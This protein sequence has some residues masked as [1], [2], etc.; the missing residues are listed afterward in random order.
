MDTEEVRMR[1]ALLLIAIVGA[2]V[3]SPVSSQSRSA[4]EQAFDRLKA[5]EGTWTDVDGTFGAKGAAAVTYKVTSG[6]HSVVE[7][8]PVGTPYEMVTVY[9]LDGNDLV[10]THY[11]SSNNQPRMKS[12]GLQG[13]LIQFAFAGGTNIDPA[14]TSHMHSARIELISADEI[15][16]TW[17]NWDQGKS[18]HS[19]T[20]RVVRKK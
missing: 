11:C 2:G 15:R 6:G 1:Y 3:I 8:F 16:A 18:D 7:T 9:H 20:F 10:L 12:A 5:L 13:N 19:A 14:K 4:A 17:E